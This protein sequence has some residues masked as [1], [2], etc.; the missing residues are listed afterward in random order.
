MF[1]LGS[2]TIG[3]LPIIRASMAKKPKE[4]MGLVVER[5]KTGNSRPRTLA[6][7]RS[8]IDAILYR[9]ISEP[10]IQS[11]VGPMI[12]PGIVTL[13][14]DKVCFKLTKTA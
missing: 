2:E 7:Q 4:R 6:A 5:L 10:D 3:E 13:T 9:Q 11:V 12:K 14:A 8:S 1:S